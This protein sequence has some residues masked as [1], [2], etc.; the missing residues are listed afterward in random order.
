[1][2]FPVGWTS[3][4]DSRSMVE[5][6]ERGLEGS[7]VCAIVGKAEGVLSVR[8]QVQVVLRTKGIYH[9]SLLIQDTRSDVWVKGGSWFLCLHNAPCI[10]NMWSRN[11]DLH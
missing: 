4:F 1:M 3:I 8:N 10:V 6:A 11:I 7:I 2:D 5:D 9:I